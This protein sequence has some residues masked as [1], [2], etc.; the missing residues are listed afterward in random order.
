MLTTPINQQSHYTVFKLIIQGVLTMTNEKIIKEIKDGNQIQ[1]NMYLLYVQN[2]PL[3]KR[4]SKAYSKLFEPE[5]LL[6]ECY[7]A[8]HKAVQ[9]FDVD[10]EYKFTTYLEK[11]VIWHFNNATR[12]KSV[13]KLSIKD[14]HL[15][16]RYNE[17]NRQEQNTTGSNISLSKACN[18]LQCSEKDI[19]RILQYISLSNCSSLDK[20]IDDMSIMD[21]IPDDTDIE[22]DYEEQEN[23]TNPKIWQCIDYVCTDREQDIIKQRYK[24]NH[25]L[26]QIAADYN[27]SLTRVQQIE[28]SAFERLR[29]NADFLKLARQNNYIDIS[30]HY[31]YGSFKY[32]GASSVEYVADVRERYRQWIATNEQKEIEKQ[33]SI[34]ISDMISK[35]L[36]P[37]D[38]QRFTFV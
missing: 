13:V 36:L 38:F 19:Q 35:G 15:L 6:Q 26:K 25:T 2:L 7:I 16:A 9:G 1:E 17:L 24:Q 10:C 11:A 8:L 28:K 33:K 4:W 22:K 3:L 30:Y 23:I 32:N 27:I 20:P 21:V 31:G 14:R 37:A 18:L 5:D 12:T 29:C 34:I